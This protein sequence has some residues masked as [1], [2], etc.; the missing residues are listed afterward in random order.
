[1]EAVRSVGRTF[2]KAEY[3]CFAF[4]SSDG[5]IF[6]ES[7]CASKRMLCGLESTMNNIR[8]DVG[9]ADTMMMMKVASI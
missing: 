6:S 4:D 7:V 9:Q 1:M 5:E 3:V 2:A 8:S